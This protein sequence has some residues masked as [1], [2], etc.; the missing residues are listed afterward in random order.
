MP[1]PLGGP[2]TGKSQRQPLIVPEMCLFLRVKKGSYRLRLSDAFPSET[3]KDSIQ[4]S[5]GMEDEGLK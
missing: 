1:L 4:P 3:D 2:L 5:F